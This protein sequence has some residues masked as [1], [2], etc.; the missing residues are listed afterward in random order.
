MDF[1]KEAVLEIQKWRRDGF[2]SSIH[3]DYAAVA[4]AMYR[5]YEQ[6]KGDDGKQ[7][8]RM[9]MLERRAELLEAKVERLQATLREAWMLTGRDD[10][11]AHLRDFHDRLDAQAYELGLRLPR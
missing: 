11:P 1:A 4:A 10:S 9:A 6:G 7:A 3:L 2:L 8:R 5:A